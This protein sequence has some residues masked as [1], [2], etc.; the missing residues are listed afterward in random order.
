MGPGKAAHEMIEEVLAPPF[1]GELDKYQ[2]LGMNAEANRMCIGLALGLCRFR[3]ESMSE[4]KDIAL[5]TPSTFAEAADVWKADS[6]G[7]ADVDVV[8]TFIEDE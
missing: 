2:K 5:D 6:L 7:W 8:K 1:L 4:F 3:H